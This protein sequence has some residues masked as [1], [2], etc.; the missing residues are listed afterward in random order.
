MEKEQIVKALEVCSNYQNFG[1]CDK[2]PAREGCDNEN[3]FLE[4]EALSLIREQEKRIEEL[5]AEN[6]KLKKPR[7]MVYSD[8]RSEMIPSVE[9]VRADTVRK[10][11]DEIKRRLLKGGIFPAFVACVIDNVAR[12]MLEEQKC[13]TT[14]KP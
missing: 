11:H 4:K 7:Y 6:E 10:M 9:S 8:G 2:C 3:G 5:E 13:D 12:E 1:D 14:E